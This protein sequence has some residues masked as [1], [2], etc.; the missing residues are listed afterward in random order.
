MIIKNK[1]ATKNW[2]KGDKCW[3]IEG[4]S[5]IP[6]RAKI[7]EIK[8]HEA[9]FLYAVLKGI[10][11]NYGTTG[12]PFDNLFLTRDDAIEAIQEYEETRTEKLENEIQTIE[13][14]VRFAYN[15]H[16]SCCEEYTDWEARKAYAN[17]AKALLGIDL[18]AKD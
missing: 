15:N 5:N 14:L 11:G 18:E 16:V 9:G 1:N 7:S 17:R 13:D 8:T 10:D 6:V 3:Y 4:W 12:R 2:K